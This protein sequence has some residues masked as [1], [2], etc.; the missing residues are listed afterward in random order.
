MK[1]V[2]TTMK[3]HVVEMTPE[4]AQR[5]LDK[6]HPNNRKPKPGKIVQ[7][8][9][10]MEA[11][12]WPLTHQAVAQDEDGFLIDG[13]NR[14]SAVVQAG[15]PVVMLLCTGVPRRAMIGADCGTVRGVADAARIIGE[16]FAHGESSYGAVARRMAV[17]VEKGRNSLSIPETLEFCHAH[18][19]AIEFAFEVFGFKKKRGITQAPVL[20]AVARAYYRRGC[21]DRLKEFG[22]VML[23]GLCGNVKN[24]SAAIRLRNWLMENTTGGRRRSEGMY[25]AQK[26]VYAK[27]QLALHHFLECRSLEALRE[28]SEEL[29]PIPAEIDNGDEVIAGKVG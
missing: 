21:R 1:I 9:R 13:Q 4:D 24:D 28:T 10:D 22:E 17:G 2:P 27:A 5:F 3:F 8:R 29:F 16:P 25:P 6:N 23:S 26:I 19:K 11:D 20:A 18:K 7:Y 12:N 14:L 15:V